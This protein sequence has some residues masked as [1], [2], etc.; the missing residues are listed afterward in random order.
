MAMTS[1]VPGGVERR[2]HPRYDLMAQ[3][4]V[5]RGQLDYVMDLVNI[6]LGGALLHMGKLDRPGWLAVGRV[7]EIGIIHP[8]DYEPL[9]VDGTIVRLVEDE[10]GTSVAVE[11]EG[12][13]DEGSEGVAKLV[14]LAMDGASSKSSGAGGPPPL[15]T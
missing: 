13:S 12:L 5:K 8:I 7:L 4:R 2:R 11:F 15:P 3:V 6:S 14:K 1:P 10:D 9:Q